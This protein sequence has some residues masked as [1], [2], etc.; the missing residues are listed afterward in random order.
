MKRAAPSHRDLS[1]AD[2]ENNIIYE[3]DT[4][5]NTSRV[6]L[7]QKCSDISTYERTAYRMLSAMRNLTELESH[8]SFT[9]YFGPIP[10]FRI[11]R[12]VTLASPQITN[13][14]F[15][16]ESPNLQYLTIDTDEAPIHTSI[17]LSTL[18]YLSG[19]T[20]LHL[21]NIDSP[22]LIQYISILPNLSCLIICDCII[23]PYED[24]TQLTTVTELSLTNDP[25]IMDITFIRQ[26]TH[27]RSLSL[28]NCSNIREINHVSSMTYLISLNL[29]GVNHI[30]ELNMTGLVQLRCLSLGNDKLVKEI[31]DAT[32]LSH[33][34]LTHLFLDCPCLYDIDELACMTSLRSL[35]L[36]DVF[37][38]CDY[39]AT[40][41]D[42]LDWIVSL[43]NL[44]TLH[45][46]EHLLPSLTILILLDNLKKLHVNGGVRDSDTIDYPKLFGHLDSFILRTYDGAQKYTDYINTKL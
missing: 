39:T 36:I 14:N 4:T 31:E 8:V 42:P 6:T 3:M 21:I 5:N 9:N 37:P 19:L 18:R 30:D 38:V 15:L 13:I 10:C 24:L 16:R 2:R 44:E 7:H 33:L 23:G 25:E 27:L 22:H 35:I 45:I 1:P 28:E 12:E 34:S 20:N 41:Y 11:L 17:D 46:R 32:V 43:D 26:M 29:L 40:D